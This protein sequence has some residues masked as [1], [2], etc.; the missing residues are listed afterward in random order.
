MDELGEELEGYSRG[1]G[2]DGIDIVTPGRLVDNSFSR[3]FHPRHGIVS[4]IM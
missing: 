3:N 2:I 4:W 1:L